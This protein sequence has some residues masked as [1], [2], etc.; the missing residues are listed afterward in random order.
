[1]ATINIIDIELL[2]DIAQV[3][4]SNE[5]NWLSIWFLISPRMRLLLTPSSNLLFNFSLSFFGKSRCSGT[6]SWPIC[7]EQKSTECLSLS[8]TEIFI[9]AGQCSSHFLVPC[10][11]TLLSPSLFVLNSPKRLQKKF[12]CNPFQCTFFQMQR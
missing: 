4:V 7:D 8:S 9:L 1:M 10:D 12:E 3:L 11:L 2:T 6:F 5:V